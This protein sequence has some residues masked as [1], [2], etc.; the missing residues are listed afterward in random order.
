MSELQELREG[1][2]KAQYRFY[3]QHKSAFMFFAD[4][5][6]LSKDDLLEVYQDACLVVFENAQKGK[7]NDLKSTL[8]SYLFGVGKFLIYKR[9]R[10]LKKQEEISIEEETSESFFDPFIEQVPNPR[11]R[12]L[13]LAIPKL[14]KKCRA[15]LSMFYFE[16][17]SLDEI[18]DTTDYKK[19]S[20]IKSQ[21]SRC[22][23]QLREIIENG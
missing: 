7:L 8:K 12:S 17:K 1:L 15:L 4:R 10:E 5:Y 11:V 22:I 18:M 2:E 20:V 16:E 6:G 3:D 13:Q 19:K 23:K 21:K 14:G 9:Y